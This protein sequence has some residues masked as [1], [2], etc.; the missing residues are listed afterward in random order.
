MSA[1]CPLGQLH[2]E[3][4]VPVDEN[5]R[6]IVNRILVLRAQAPAYRLVHLKGYRICGGTEQPEVVAKGSLTRSAGGGW[7]FS[8]DSGRIGCVPLKQVLLQ[9]FSPSVLH[10]RVRKGSAL[11]SAWLAHGA[12]AE[13]QA[14]G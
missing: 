2:T 11:T 14:L 5:V 4:L 7:T 10:P 9:L 6:Q 13:G 12:A 1:A 3:R 8:S